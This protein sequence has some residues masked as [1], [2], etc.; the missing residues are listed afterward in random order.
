MLGLYRMPLYGRPLFLG[1][2]AGMIV[3][4]WSFVLAGLKPVLP[5]QL[6]G[7]RYAIY[8]GVLALVVN[9]VIGLAGSKLATL[10]MQNVKNQHSS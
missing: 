6:L 10:G 7:G 3:G 1:W 2:V 9:L 5:I 4:T 8:V